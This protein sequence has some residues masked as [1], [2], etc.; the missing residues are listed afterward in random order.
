[1]INYFTQDNPP[2]G[3]ISWV[4]VLVWLAAL[5]FGIYLVRTY[6]DSNPIRLRFARQ[7]GMITAVLGGIGV[8]LLALKFFQVDVLEWRLWSYLVAFASLGY[9]GY[10]LY[11][12]NSKLPEQVAAARPSRVIR[13]T[14]SR[15][16]R[17]YTTGGTTEAAR[18][19]REPRPIATTTRR[20]ARRDKKRKTR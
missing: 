2:F 12:Y 20:E 16:A 9:W 3:N 19:A 11:Y 6:R 7:V 1:M 18:P 8:I 10:A 17:T 4:M 14:P 5:A 15:G 13:G